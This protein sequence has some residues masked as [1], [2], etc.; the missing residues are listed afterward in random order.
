MATPA[1]TSS[2]APPTTRLAV[3][4]RPQ[5]L[6]ATKVTAPQTVPLDDGRILQALPGDWVITRT[7]RPIDVV[8][9]GILRER[10]QVVEPTALSI[11][12]ATCTRL[13]HTLG[14]GAT[15]SVDRLIAAVERLASIS[16]G[17]IKIAFTPGQLDEIATRAR[18]RGQTVEQALVAVIDRIREELFWRN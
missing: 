3:V 13:E 1:S 2:P 14:I 12:P 11:N 8:G 4:P 10:Y 7:K 18:K 15:Q 16:I 5:P 9:D 6:T 17:T